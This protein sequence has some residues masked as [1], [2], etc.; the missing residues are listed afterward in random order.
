MNET[1]ASDVLRAIAFYQDKGGQLAHI[2]RL[3]Q[4]VEALHEAGFIDGLEAQKCLLEQEKRRRR[5]SR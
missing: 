1:T 3:I 2:L 4:L 5:E